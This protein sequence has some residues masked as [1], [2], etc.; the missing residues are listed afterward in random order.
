MKTSCGCGYVWGKMS[1]Y[2][3]GTE[4]SSR[5]GVRRM[6]KIESKIAIVVHESLEIRMFTSHAI[7]HTIYKDFDHKLN[8]LA[9]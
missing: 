5:W 8:S 6:Q 2:L 4:E 9:P 3:I 7:L 1:T